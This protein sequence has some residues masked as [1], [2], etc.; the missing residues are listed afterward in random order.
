MHLFNCHLPAKLAFILYNK[1]GSYQHLIRSSTRPHRSDTVLSY[2]MQSCAI[3]KYMV[4]E[5]PLNTTGKRCSLVDLQPQFLTSFAYTISLYSQLYPQNQI[6][7]LLT[8]L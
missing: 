7:P 5:N 6:E 4:L 2:I 8:I 3:E 1:L